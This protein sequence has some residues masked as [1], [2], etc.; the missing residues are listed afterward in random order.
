MTLKSKITAIL[1][2]TSLLVLAIG[3]KQEDQPERP[4]EHWVFRS[5]L[6][7]QPRILTAALHEDLWV[8]YSTQDGLLHKAWD[9]DVNFSGAVYDEMHG[10]QPTT[11]GIQFYENTR[12][13]WILRNEQEAVQPVI[14]YKGHQFKNGRLYLS[15]LL[16]TPA[17]DSIQVME[18]PEFVK[19]DGKAALE[20]RFEVSNDTDYQL[21]LASDAFEHDAIH[22]EDSELT[23]T[24]S[25]MMEAPE[26]QIAIRENTTL[27]FTMDHAKATPIANDGNSDVKSSANAAKSL[28][29][30]SDCRACHNELVKTVGPSYMAIAKRYHDNEE[31]KKLLAD[32]I[33]HGGKGS[34]G[35]AMMTPHEQF[36]E[37]QA[38]QIAEYILNIDDTLETAV[39]KYT[40]GHESVKFLRPSTG[41]TG[42]GFLAKIYSNPD[43]QDILTFRD[44]EQADLSRIAPAIHT[45]EKA[46]FEVASDHFAI[47]YDG[48][49]NIEKAGSY[50]FRLISDDGSYL[51]ID[52]K[53]VIDNSGSH[54]SRIKD[55][56]VHLNEGKHPIQVVY[57]QGE[58]GA[59]ISLQ[60]FD[61]EKEAYSLLDETMISHEN[62]AVPTNEKSPERLASMES[63][64]SPSLKGVHPS[65]DLHQ[66]R[67]DDFKPKVGGI[68]FLEDGT[69]VVC[70]W[71]PDGAVYAI[72]N[73]Q[74]QDP[75][76]IKVKKIAYGLAEPLGLKVVDGDIYVLQKQ[77]LTQLLDHD[78]DGI[79]DEY[80]TVSNQWKVSG[81]FHEFAFGLVYKD[82]AF[83]A[84][85]ATAIQP[86]GAS[87][88]PQ[89][90]DRG[91]A[92][93][94]DPKTGD[95]QFVASGLRTPNG[96]GLGLEE[97][98][99]I[100][101]NQG[102]WL[103]ASK[104][105]HLQQ[106]AFYGSRSVDPEASLEKTEQLPVVW[107]PQDEIGNSPSTPIGIDLGPYK[108]QLLVGEVT[109]G[110]IKRI[111]VEE[112]NGQ[113]Q[114][115]LFRFTQG[116][117]AGV[118]RLQWAPDGS[119]MAGGVG[120]SGN[121]NHYGTYWYGLQRLV[122]NEKSTFEI[123]SVSA[124][125]GGFRIELTEPL[126]KGTEITTGDLHMEQWR[127]E[128]TADYGGP[129]L[130]H[131]T[132]KAANVVLGDDHKTLEVSLPEMKAG[133]VVYFKLSDRFKNGEGQPLWNRE[134]WYTLNHIPR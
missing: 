29:E 112:V 100:S 123:L 46:D 14:R 102:D 125:A 77:E 101:D 132:L 6:D 94:I 110:G 121:W 58:G 37:E 33:I 87:A 129:K 120:S 69:M 73:W 83:Y 67:P 2:A 41:N 88:S 44:A 54:G 99:F 3:C 111:Y 134:S 7:T 119:L 91:K 39:S 86:G 27:T 8:A 98:I 12:D 56:E 13:R 64:P 92:I 124:R 57:G 106:D 84:T 96:I 36:S 21:F 118:N 95:V 60:V 20:R 133:H 75:S 79:I 108:D 15:T 103:P 128:P 31:N 65:F 16:I 115:A 26:K 24:P 38:Y 34:W 116:M 71:D 55:G 68:D 52:G 61:T 50:A 109:N 18:S 11:T 74:S 45:N 113:L 131:E 93:R 105:V 130:D 63:A 70:T 35:E 4:R 22:L 23:D 17:Q 122:Y 9:G 25:A 66:A 48:L 19:K 1:Y 78:Q 30:A 59:M 114:G 51:F 107:M 97:Q 40:L 90:P 82:K 47:V 76:S 127:Y 10:P 42:K 126:A 104:V 49:L 28:V 85:L 89:I 43:E 62:N 80:R 5:V 117:E 53:Q 81:N 32:K 72:R